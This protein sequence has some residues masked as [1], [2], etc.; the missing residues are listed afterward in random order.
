MT[1]LIS[2]TLTLLTILAA[3]TI[4][5]ITKKRNQRQLRIKQRKGISWLHSMRMLLTH[6]QKHRGL[7]SGYHGGE[8]ALLKE[9]NS[10]QREI[11]QDCAAISLIGDGIQKNERWSG[12]TEHWSRLSRQYQSL[13]IDSNLSQHNRLITNL[14]YLI[15]DI[16]ETHEL[17]KLSDEPTKVSFVWKELLIAAEHIGQARALGTAITAAGRCSSVSRIR[18]TYLKNKI[19]DTTRTAGHNLDVPAQLQSQV[20]NF[21]SCINDKVMVDSP[22]VSAQEYFGIATHCLESI[23]AQ[24]DSELQALDPR[25]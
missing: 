8:T 5:F 18:M 19:D 14:L 23:L 6:L 21:L 7:T 12:I 11:Q 16:A 4:M 22:Q 20:S 9:I 1:E 2:I 15:E 24:F 10:I 13:N 3:F 25:N 17:K